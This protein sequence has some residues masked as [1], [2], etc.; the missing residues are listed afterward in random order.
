M[1]LRTNMRKKFLII[2]ALLVSVLASS[3]DLKELRLEYPKAVENVEIFT[4]FDGELAKVNSLSKAVLLAYKGAAYTLKAKFA[5]ERKDKKEFFREGASLLESAVKAD[6]E[7]IEIR[8]IRL[9]VQEN[10][11]KVLKYNK[12][13]EEDKEFVLKNYATI[14]SKELKGIIKEFALKS[15]TFSDLE[16]SELQ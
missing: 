11:P 5:K 15:D 10:T 9:S 1:D 16:K 12:D 3:Q 8:Y 6:P 14:S 4:K 13:I 7:N 2:V